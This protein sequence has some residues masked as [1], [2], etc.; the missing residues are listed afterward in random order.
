M[1]LMFFSIS[2]YKDIRK[3]CAMNL[4]PEKQRLTD[5]WNSASHKIIASKKSRQ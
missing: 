4:K 2:G 5:I 3:S 1:L